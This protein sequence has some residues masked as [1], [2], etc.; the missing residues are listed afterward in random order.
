MSDR[1]FYEEAGGHDTIAGIIHRFYE[2]VA[3]DPD[4]RAVYPD[5]DLRPAERRLT[6]FFEQY[7]GGPTT[8]SEQRGHPRLGMRHSRFAVTLTQASRWLSHMRDALDEANLSPEHNA[9]F[10]EYVQRAAHFLINTPDDQ[11]AAEGPA[12]PGPDRPSLD[13]A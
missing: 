13:L 8:Y 7:W 1:T 6:M 12:V 5:E 2:R 9:Q 10:W 3:S 11:S 4:L